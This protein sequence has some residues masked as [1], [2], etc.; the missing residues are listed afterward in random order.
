[1]RLSSRR[2]SEARRSGQRGWALGRNIGRPN[3]SSCRPQR[4]VTNCSRADGRRSARR[5]GCPCVRTSHVALTSGDG[6]CSRPRHRPP[7]RIAAWRGGGRPLV[8]EPKCAG[9]PAPVT[10]S[11]PPASGTPRPGGRGDHRIQPDV[12]LRERTEVGQPGQA[13]PADPMHPERDQ[14]DV[15]DAVQQVGPGPGGSS[16]ATTRAPPASAGTPG[17]AIAG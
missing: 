15:R 7:A 9:P 5:R 8:R 14:A 6:W 3:Q 13:E 12:R 10:V 1:M 17:H 11:T 2:S 4:A 16:G